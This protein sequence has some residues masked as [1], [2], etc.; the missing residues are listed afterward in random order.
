MQGRRRPSLVEAITTSN[1]KLLVLLD[2]GSTSQHDPRPVVSHQRGRTMVD[3]L[4]S[5]RSPA[6]RGTV[7]T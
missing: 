3:H 6:F 1:K 7:S 5:Y 2:L 4:E